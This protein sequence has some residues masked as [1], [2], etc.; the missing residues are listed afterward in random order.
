[1]AQ[2]SLVLDENTF[3]CLPHRCSALPWRWV[4]KGKEGENKN[5]GEMGWRGRGERRG[6]EVGKDDCLQRFSLC[7]FSLPS[8][9]LLLSGGLAQPYGFFFSAIVFI[10]YH[11][12]SQSWPPLKQDLEKTRGW[13]FRGRARLEVMTVGPAL[14]CCP[15]WIQELPRFLQ[16]H[17]ALE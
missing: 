2:T 3:K 13:R 5:E 4:F 10:F 1:M 11:S 6:Q 17:R 9:G 16:T 15:P 14:P 12:G 7:W 8:E